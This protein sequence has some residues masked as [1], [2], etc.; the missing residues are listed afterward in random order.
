MNI[1]EYPELKETYKDHQVQLLAPHRTT[2]KSKQRSESIVQMLLKLRQA[3]CCDHCSGEPVPM[4]DNTSSEEP[5]FL[6]ILY[7]NKRIA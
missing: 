1:V 4:S 6:C 7:L 5:Y 2:Q 3:Q